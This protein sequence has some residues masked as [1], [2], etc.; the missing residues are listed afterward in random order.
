VTARL[1]VASSTSPAAS[2]RRRCRDAERH[3]IPPE[4]ISSV[5]SIV[6]FAEQSEEE[7]ESA[8]ALPHLALQFAGRR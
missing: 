4:E 7:L 1:Q 6:D 5:G 3:R 2:A 8:L